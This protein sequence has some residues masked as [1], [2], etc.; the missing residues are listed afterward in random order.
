MGALE[1]F[2]SNDSRRLEA[3]FDHCFSDTENTLLVGGA[4]E[5]VYRP[6]DVTQ[7]RNLLYYR[8]DFFASALHEVAH[9]CIAGQARRRHVDFGYWYAPEGRNKR[10][11]RA[12]ESV[13]VKPQALEWI[14][15]RACGFRFQ[16][17]VDNL[18]PETGSLPDTSEFRAQVLLE[19]RRRAELGL[20]ARAERFFHALCTEFG[21]DLRLESMEFTACLLYTSPS[22]RDA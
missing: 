20:P 5:P 8:E 12:F 4:S 10:Q 14:F 9:W 11:Q 1:S 13:E 16:V 15:S 22:P 6:S 2:Y 3:V 7:A 18:D 21:T 19:A 17:S